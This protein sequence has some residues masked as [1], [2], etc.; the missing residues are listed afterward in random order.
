MADQ[1][2]DTTGV[3]VTLDELTRLQFQARGFS[4]LPKQPLHSLLA[5]RHTSRMRGRGL[6]FEELRHYLP[7]DD[8]RTIDWKVTARTG[9][10]HV[11]V[12]T[13]ERDRPALIIVDQRIAMFYGTKVAMKSVVAA[14]AAALAAWRVVDVGDRV[15]GV[16]FNDTDVAEVKPHRSGQTVLRFLHHLVEQNT[17]L[18]ADAPVRSNPSALNAVLE[19]VA[20]VAKHDYLVVVIS[21]F[22]GADDRT[23]RLI[24]RMSQHNDIIVVPVFDPSSQDLPASGRLV[25]GDGELQIEVDLGKASSLRSVLEYTRGRLDSVLRWR[26]EIGVPVL[27]LST[28]EPVVEQVRRLLGQARAGR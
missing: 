14:Q 5:G 18:R 15:G 20:R 2:T 17:A 25:V 10:T 26:E 23:I 4:F 24:T 13:E 9:K 6:D 19:G 8:S 22:D 11:R 21:D 16:V 28:A 1:P 7:G 12:Y 3:W 27:P